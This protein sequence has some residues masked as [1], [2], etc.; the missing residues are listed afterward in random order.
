MNVVRWDP[1]RDLM[2]IQDRVQR[3]LTDQAVHFNGEEGYGAWVPA[4]DFPSPQVAS[5]SSRRASRS[6]V[7]SR[8]GK[9]SSMVLR[10]AR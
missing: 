4:V 6:R 7:A 1:F 10:N 9:V 5:C 8:T 3:L 2:T